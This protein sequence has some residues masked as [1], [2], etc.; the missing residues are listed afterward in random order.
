MKTVITLISAMALAGLAGEV[1]LAQS[2]SATS[3]HP[4]CLATYTIE[5][6]TV[7]NPSTILFHTRDGRTYVNTLKA[8][9]PGLLLHGF[10]YLTHS[11]EICSNAVPIAVV[12]THQ[13]C[14]LGVF[15]PAPNAKPWSYSP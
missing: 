14:A 11:S 13:A 2:P 1:A 10:V 7:V 3:L 12:Q 15:E 5:G 4:L 8:P 9:C 6:T